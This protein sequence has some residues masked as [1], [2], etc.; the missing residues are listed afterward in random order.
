VDAL[1]A[2]AEGTV[3]LTEPRKHLEARRVWVETAGGKNVVITWHEAWHASLLGQLRR[4][5]FD[6][7][8]TPEQ[9]ADGPARLATRL[10]VDALD[11]L[12]EIGRAARE[13]CEA[14][15]LNPGRLLAREVARRAL[16]ARALYPAHLCPAEVLRGAD[17]M[18][19]GAARTRSLAEWDV[20]ALAGAAAKSGDE[21]VVTAMLTEVLRWVAWCKVMTGWESRPVRPNARCPH[22]DAM[23]GVVDD[24]PSGLRIRWDRRSAV[25]LSCSATWGPLPLPPIEIL[26]KHIEEEAAAAASKAMEPLPP[27]P[28]SQNRGSRA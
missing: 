22:C 11:R 16:E 26:A 10:N 24:H 3:A 21:R 1:A 7:A 5:T 8:Q 23:A 9:A 6:P 27:V 15:G 17:Q 12:V 19:A 20:R 25:C 2:L 4:A 14:Y 18:L 13:R 28:M